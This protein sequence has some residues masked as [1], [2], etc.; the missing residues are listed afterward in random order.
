MTESLGKRR[1]GLARRL[2]Q[3]RE[4]KGFNQRDLARAASTTQQHIS[5]I[6]RGRIQAPRDLARLADALGKS[7]AWL[8]YGVEAIDELSEDALEVA[9]RVNDLT[10][11]E[12]QALLALLRARHPGALLPDTD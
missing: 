4:E 1:S 8:Q 3:A 12:R 6:E 9:F 5:D 7:P 2:R 11:E 10:D